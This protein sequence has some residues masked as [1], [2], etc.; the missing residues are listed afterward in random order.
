MEIKIN[1]YTCW[2]DIWY[3]DF[4]VP[5]FDAFA[6][7]GPTF[8]SRFGRPHREIPMGKA[9]LLV[10][11]LLDYDFLLCC[12]TRSSN[13]M[14]L[15][16]P[17]DVTIFLFPWVSQHDLMQPIRCVP[18]SW[19]SAPMGAPWPTCSLRLKT[20]V[21]WMA[22]VSGS[23]I[24]SA[25][26]ESNGGRMMDLWWILWC[27]PAWTQDWS[28]N[29]KKEIWSFPVVLV[30]ASWSLWAQRQHMKGCQETKWLSLVE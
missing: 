22:T 19:W 6:Q 13:A 9:C 11:L 21:A 1:Q 15:T 4:Q 20:Q 28:K 29:V 30:E 5:M 23:H 16:A 17:C 27:F 25:N 7:V 10:G 18:P 14:F 2:Y 12:S 24:L 26:S 3:D 8:W